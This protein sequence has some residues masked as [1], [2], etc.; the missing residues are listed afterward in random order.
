M[1]R[2]RRRGRERGRRLPGLPRPEALLEERPEVRLGDVAHHDE[3]RV[4]RPPEAV[5]ERGEVPRRRR[6]H[7]LLGAE[8][9]VAVRVR[10]PEHRLERLRRDRLG[11]VALLQ[12]HHEPLVLHALE[13]GPSGTPGS[14]RRRRRGR[15]TSGGA[16]RAS[17]RRASRSPPRRRRRSTRRGS[18][19]RR[20]SGSRCGSGCPRSSSRRRSSRGPAASAGSRAAPASTTRFSATIGRRRYSTSRTASPFESVNFFWSGTRSSGGGPFSGGVVR[21]GL[22]G[23]GAGRRR[24]RRGRSRR[25]RAAAAPPC[26][27]RRTRRRARARARRGCG[28]GGSSGLP[29]RGGGRGGGRPARRGTTDRTTR[30]SLR[31]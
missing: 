27:A 10:A 9:V 5:V 1:R 4:R 18:P 23:A 8:R 30:A 2:G 15:G 12:E 13:V 16:A 21:S 6:L 7:R 25:G 22:R 31:R 20:R 3:L 11:L 28:R 26:A 29:L 14:S 19:P 17:R 24:R